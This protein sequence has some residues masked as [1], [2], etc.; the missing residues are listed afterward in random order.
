M[1]AVLLR[2]AYFILV[3]KRDQKIDLSYPKRRR[4]RSQLYPQIA[5]ISPIAANF[6][7]LFIGA[8][9]YQL[10][11]AQLDL[12]SFV[13]IT[14][15][16]P[17]LR[18]GTQFVSAWAQASAINISQALGRDEIQFLPI[19][20]S[21][22]TRAALGLSLVIALLFFLFSQFVYL[23]YPNIEPETYAA[24]TIIAPLY[25]LLPVI[26]GYN[27]VSGN[28]LRALGESTR[29][30][31]LH[32]VTQWVISLPLCALLVLSLDVSVFWAFA[33]MP[34]EELLKMY[35]FHRY[36]R[37]NMQRICKELSV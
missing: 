7:V 32:F 31:K 30:L 29:I 27:S 5:E 4:F 21:A 19:F 1:C 36:M 23:V 17:W 22:C 18:I 2:T 10:I 26:R 34:L 8:S 20:I 11:Y 37:M 28:I 12:A 35:P 16:F 25:I 13:A 24:I 3:L 15:I 9:V 33:V 14:L 6:F